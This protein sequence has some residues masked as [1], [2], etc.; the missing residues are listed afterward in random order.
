MGVKEFFEPRKSINI[1]KSTF[2]TSENLLF[3]SEDNFFK[4]KNFSM[5][6]TI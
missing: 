5:Y 2:F 4:S 3:T 6:K 1:N